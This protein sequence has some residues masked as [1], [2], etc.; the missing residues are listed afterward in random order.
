MFA[1]VI[2][3]FELPYVYT[4]DTELFG[5]SCTRISSCFIKL[6]GAHKIHALQLFTRCVPLQTRDEKDEHEVIFHEKQQLEPKT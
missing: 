1:H 6:N 5:I 4:N 2:V 3:A